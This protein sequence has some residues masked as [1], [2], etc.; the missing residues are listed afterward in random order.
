MDRFLTWLSPPYV[1]C[2]LGIAAVLWMLIEYLRCKRRLLAVII[3]MGSGIAT[4]VLAHCYGAAIGFS[5]PLNLFTVSVSLV[6]GVPGV[7]LMALLQWL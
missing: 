4:L 2:V 5:P 1:L 3:G 7:L 6:G